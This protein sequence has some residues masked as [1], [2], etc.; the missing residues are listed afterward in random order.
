M[1]SSVQSEHVDWATASRF[2]RACGGLAL[3][4]LTLPNS[5]AWQG[6]ASPLPSGYLLQGLSATDDAF[7]LSQYLKA[8]LL[9]A[10]FTIALFNSCC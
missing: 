6:F 9:L 1:I 2:A 3:L 7:V 4:S 5:P 10:P 8:V